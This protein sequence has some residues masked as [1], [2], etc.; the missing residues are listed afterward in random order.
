MGLEA[1]PDSYRFR[2]MPQKEWNFMKNKDASE[3]L[4]KWS[5]RDRISVQAFCYDKHLDI[6][7]RVEFV[8]EF[9]T[10][11]TILASL[12]VLTEANKWSP[13]MVPAASVSVELVPCTE[14]TM[15]LFDKL[16]DSGIVRDNGNIRKCMEEWFGDLVLADELR[17]LLGGG[18]SD[19]EDVFTEAEQSEFLFRLFRHLALG[20]RWCQYE[21]NVQPYLD[22][23]KLIYKELVSVCKSSD[24]VGLRVTSQVLKVTAKSED[25][26]DL[27]PREA[28]HPQNFLYLLVNPLKRSVLTLYHQ[29]GALL[30]N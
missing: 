15:R 29:F 30:Q 28:D 27:I 8:Q 12:K 11:P 5:L 16:T 21:D 14:T 24:S 25:G 23:T 7:N 20:G 22:V 17:K 26:S 18:E 3:C 10:E 2:L 6:H 1:K 9:L 19:Y 4:M 13:L